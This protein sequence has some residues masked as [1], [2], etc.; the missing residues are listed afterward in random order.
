MKTLRVRMRSIPSRSFPYCQFV[1]GFSIIVF[2]FFVFAASAWAAAGKQPVT[3]NGDVVEFKADGR[4][5]VAEGNVEIVGQEMRMK[6]DRVR[7]FMDEKLVIAEGNVYFRKGLEEMQGEMIVFDFG[8]GSGTLIEPKVRMAPYYGRAEVMDR[9]ASNEI[10]L[11]N[12]LLSTCDLPHPHYSL[13]CEEV[14]TDKDNMMR[15]KGIKLSVLGLPLMYLPAYSHRLTDKRPRF[16]ITPGHRKNYG[17]ELFGMWRYYLNPNAKGVLHF[18]W[19]QLKGW[20]QGID[21]NYNT[22]VIGYGNVKYYRIDE[23]D[24]REEIPESQR[25][26]NERSRVEVRH[27]WQMTAEDQAV[28]EYFRA[29]DVN[30]RKDYFY[31]EYEKDPQ[32]A[33]FFQYTHSFPN[34]IFSF[35]AQPRVNHFETVLQKI[36]EV[37]LE[38]FSQKIGDTNFYFKDIS[39]AD[40]LSYAVANSGNRTEVMRADTS[41]QLSYLFRWLGIDFGPYVGHQDTFYSRGVDSDGSLIRGMFFSGLDVSTKLYKVFDLETNAWGLD[42]HKLRHIITPTAQ[43]RYQHE[44]T[45]GMSRL[46][47]LDAIDSL[48]SLNRVTLGLENKLQ[49]KRNDLEVDLLRVLLSADYFFE[50]NNSYEEGFSLLKYEMEFKPYSW[51][52]LDGDAEYDLRKERFNAVNAEFWTAL[53][54]LST[55]LGF[56][57]AHSE[58][59]QM[60]AGFG[61]QLNPFWNFQLYE[62]FELDSGRFI[63]QEYRLTRDMHCWLMELIVNQRETEGVSV[64]VAFTL[65]A[66]PEIGINAETTFSPPRTE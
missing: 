11:R 23:K 52:E 28:F 10:F 15:A 14:T 39:S 42:I 12:A 46:Q 4:E 61:Y 32:P 2:C 29:S 3:V 36:P 35:L 59:S 6:A 54:K 27:K 48:D 50:S 31:R 5:I 40:F 20:A 64:L 43:Y 58:N 57:Y 62:R 19:Y 25:R 8:E 22:K 56:R 9:T 66:F 53:G 44:P 41:N 34:A 17:M 60:T 47:Q 37:R 33:S 1:R 38:T 26:N 51:W 49:T 30:F 45:V 16:E 7:V 63:E 24:T 21:L 18:D 13:S 65:K 55:H